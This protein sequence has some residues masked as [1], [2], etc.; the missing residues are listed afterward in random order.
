MPTYLLIK[1]R[2]LNLPTP[3]SE[4]GLTTTEKLSAI[5]QE[6]ADTHP[7]QKCRARALRDLKELRG[8]RE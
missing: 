2:G 4:K 5:L 6:I 8:E 3:P 7:D 1:S